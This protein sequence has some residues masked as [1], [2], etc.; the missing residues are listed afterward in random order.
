MAIILAGMVVVAL[1][2]AGLVAYAISQADFDLDLSSLEG[3]GIGPTTKSSLDPAVMP[4]YAPVCSAAVRASSA[5]TVTEGTVYVRDA[6]GQLRA[7]DAATCA[8]RWS[9]G[10][11]STSGLAVDF[12]PVVVGGGAYLVGWDGRVRAFDAA[13]GTLRWESAPLDVMGVP[14]AVANGVVYVHADGVRAFDAATGAERWTAF[15]GTPVLRSYSAPV[16]D[17]VTV[18]IGA[19]DGAVHAYDAATGAQRWS[20]PLTTH[21]GPFGPS[22]SLAVSDGTLYAVDRDGVVHAVD[23]ATGIRRWQLP[24]GE[25]NTFGSAPTIVGDTVYVQTNALYAI[26]S[27]GEQQWMAALGGSTYAFVPPTVDGG[28][29]YAGGGDGLLHVV[30]ATTGIERAALGRVSPP[31]PGD[32]DSYNLSTAIPPIIANGLLYVSSGDNHVYVYKPA[33]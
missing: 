17:G 19:G 30:D 12:A 2:G 1:A 4:G 28:L 13:T 21:T 9:A 6:S 24:T 31:A 10:T 18:Y 23:A 14:L 33:S 3:L 16:V 25:A 26:S 5:A 8:P 15:V 32:T 22:L 7:F 27:A 20:T 11:R 29:V